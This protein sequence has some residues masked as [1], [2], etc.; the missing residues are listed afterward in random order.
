MLASHA[1]CSSVAA[2][3]D[4]DDDDEN[5]TGVRWH[6]NIFFLYARDNELLLRRD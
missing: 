3:Y 1:R 5:D 2:P 6:E 4:D